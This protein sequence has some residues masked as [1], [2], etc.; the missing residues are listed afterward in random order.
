MSRSNSAS[1]FMKYNYGEDRLCLEREELAFWERQRRCGDDCDLKMARDLPDDTPQ[2]ILRLQRE[3]EERATAFSFAGSGGMV[4]DAGCGNGELL[5]AA[6]EMGMAKENGPRFIGMDFSANML[7]RARFRTSGDPRAAFLQG[8][9]TSLPFVDQSFDWVVSS[10]VLTCLASPQ[11][12]AEAL[13]EFNRVLRPGGGL[14]VDFFNR[15]SHYTLA[16]KYLFGERIVPP[17]YLSFSEFQNQ[18]ENA[19]FQI[20][21]HLGFDFKLCQGYL[22]MSRY[23]PVVDPAYLQERISQLLEKRIVPLWPKLSLFGYR[24]YVRCKKI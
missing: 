1:E 4:L 17:E 24:I 5:I 23:R 10:G 11:S 6:L 15:L 16:R 3:F 14:V 22:F 8:S 7:G 9:I 21:V 13:Q 2:F 19:G 20:E 18:L 12:M